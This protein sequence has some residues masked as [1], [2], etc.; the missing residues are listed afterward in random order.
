MK[1]WWT[2]NVIVYNGEI[3]K[4]LNVSGACL[5]YWKYSFNPKMF[6]KKSKLN[7]EIYDLK[8]E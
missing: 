4:K 6:T 1:R 7:L 3:I 8:D 5:G 2:T